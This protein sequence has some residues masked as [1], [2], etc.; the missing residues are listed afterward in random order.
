MEELKI[1][2]LEVVV[3]FNLSNLNLK[4]LAG[5]TKINKVALNPLD[6]NVCEFLNFFSQK[7]ISN[8]EAR[9]YS[10]LI[11]LS[12]W[13]SKKNINKLKERFSFNEKRLGRGL[14]FHVT[15][16]NVPTNFFYSLIFGILSGNSNIVKVPSND[17]PQIDLICKILN[18]ILKIK[19]F[20][21][22]KNYIC[23]VKYKDEKLN[24]STKILSE[25][26]DLRVIWGGDNTIN[27]LREYKILPHA[28]DITFGDKYS[29][30]IINSKIFDKISKKKLSSLIKNFYNDTYLV[31]QNA[32]SSPHLIL[33][34]G[35]K[36]KS[37]KLK[38]WNEL[39][40]KILKDYQL[41]MNAI[42]EKY[43][44]YCIDLTKKYIK[45]GQI[46]SQSLYTIELNKLY[47]DLE[48]LK[49][50]W[51]YFYEINIDNIDEMTNYITK[52]FQTLTYFGFNKKFFEKY[53]KNNKPLGI[54]R[55]VPIGKGLN[56]GLFW[57]GYDVI[58]TLSRVV[59]FE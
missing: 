47:L 56:I 14:I 17:F 22:F 59:H 32:C 25:N 41:P 34:Y 13:C 36:S 18:E 53:I 55:I 38:F 33:W 37:A 29:L 6:K 40:K 9:K 31:D 24:D 54:D 20:N 16:S 44:K 15:P 1:Q 49:G 35:K 7:L 10:D 45:R 52:K 30:S 27:Q 11:A 58:K 21:Y 48:S 5:S 4:I 50:K 23:I 43:N 3:M 26:C 2:L 8:K 51:G 57:D 19:K 46:F 39:N 12:F 42:T 28:N